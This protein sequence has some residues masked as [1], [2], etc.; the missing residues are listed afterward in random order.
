MGRV[1]EP[2]VAL[3]MPGDV[4]PGLFSDRQDGR[5]PQRARILV[6]NIDR[7]TRRV[8]DRIVGPRRQLILTAI[9]RPRVPGAGLRDLKAEDRIGHDID[10][11][12][13]SPLPLPEDGDVLTAVIDEPSQA[14]EELEF[15][16]RRS[17][18]GGRLR[19]SCASWR[20]EQARRSLSPRELLRERSLST[21]EHGPGRRL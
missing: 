11:G 10:P 7:F 3:T 4:G 17:V 20:D 12:R 21:Q 1:L 8:A 6:P 19:S 15:W 5:I 14:V 9:H 2:A 13:W 16:A 18:D